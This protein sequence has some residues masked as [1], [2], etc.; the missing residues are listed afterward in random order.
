MGSNGNGRGVLSSGI[1]NQ[2][3]LTDALM[4]L[5]LERS[6]CK[7]KLVNLTPKLSYDVLVS[8]WIGHHSSSGASLGLRLFTGRT[9]RCDYLFLAICDGICCDKLGPANVKEF[10]HGTLVTHPK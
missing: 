1:H 4:K 10:T 8:S 7:V 9:D 3:G 6:G 5:I 2:K